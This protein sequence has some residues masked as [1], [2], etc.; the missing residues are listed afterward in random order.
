MSAPPPSTELVAAALADVPRTPEQHF[1]LALFGVI[2]RIVEACADGDIDAALQAYPFLTDYIDEIDARTGPGPSP[3]ARWRPALSAWEGETA[4]AGV[5]LP[6]V[7]L[8]RAGLGALDIELLLAVGLLDEDPRF[9]TVFEQAQRNERRPTFGLLLAWWRHNPAG[10]DRADEV[11]RSLQHLVNQ[12]LLHVPNA[13]APR[14]D[15]TPG[16][17]LAV[18]DALRG[19][20]PS[21]RW[22][23]H[24]PLAALPALSDYVAAPEARAACFAL[25]ALLAQQPAHVLL[26]RGPA[27]NGRKTLVAAVARALGKSLLIAS[28]AVFEDEPRWRLFGAVATMADALPVVEFDLAPGETRTLPALPLVDGPLALVTGRYGAWTCADARP[29]LTVEVPL[30]AVEQRLVHW[31][32]GL[33]LETGQPPESLAEFAAQARLTSGNIRRVASTAAGFAKLSGREAV[34]CDHVR[35]ACRTLQAARL[36]TLATRLPTQGALDD[37]AVDDLTREELDALTARCRFREQLASTSAPVAQG[38]VGVRALL[39]GPSGTGKTLAARLLAAGLGKDLYRVDLSAAVNKYLGETEKNLNQAFTAAEEL[40][41][42]FLLDEGDALMAARTEVGSSNDRYANLE[43]NFLLQRIESFDGIL[44]VTSNAADR[45]DKAFARRMDVV[46]NFRPP[47]EWRR[48]DILKLHLAADDVDDEWL[49]RVACRCA[50][51]GGQ[52]RNVASHAWLMALQAGGTLRTEHVHAALVREYRK[53]GG[54]CPLR[55]ADAVRH[56]AVGQG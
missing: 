43:T 30:P 41:V 51:S 3:C 7:A 16:V 15:W 10:E 48:Y 35:R 47:D 21:L 9:G 4:N 1:R 6:L 20:T 49:Q 37:L 19:E 29:M 40:D 50:L 34:A 25:P 12:G 8:Q 55:P 31:R 17:T 26:V 54:D 45:I 28:D 11:R 53:T 42:V 36:E 24:V 56:A 52:L 44:L 2:A 18:W 14:P 46:I 5:K 22:L 27:H 23:K 32:A 38:N 13:D 39:A 33:P